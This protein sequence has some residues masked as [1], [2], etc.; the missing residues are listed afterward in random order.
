MTLKMNVLLDEIL[1]STL[2]T[3]FF[4]NYK[5]Y[6][7][8]IKSFQSNQNCILNAHLLCLFHHIHHL[9]T[10]LFLPYSLPVSDSTISHVQE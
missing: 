6:K 3:F 8:I 9:D 10:Y 7:K 2:N 4:A 5:A 1:T